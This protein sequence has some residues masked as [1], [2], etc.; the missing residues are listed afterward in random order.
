VPALVDGETRPHNYVRSGRPDLLIAARAAIR[1]SRRDA[2]QAPHNPFFA[3]SIDLD[4]LETTGQSGVAVFV[5]SNTGR[6][7][8]GRP[9][10]A[11]AHTGTVSATRSAP[12]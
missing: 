7:P 6:R 3:A 4:E 12:A 2:G 9:G 8:A 11:R 1:L 10:S 5:C